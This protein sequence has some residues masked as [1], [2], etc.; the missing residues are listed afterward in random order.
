MSKGNLHPRLAA[1]L[2]VLSLAACGVKNQTGKA[3]VPTRPGNMKLVVAESVL[4]TAGLETVL[5]KVQRV[6]VEGGFWGLA[7]DSGERYNPLNDL[8][9][10]MERDGVRARLAVSLRKDVL[11]TRMWGTPVK[12]YAY[13]LLEEPKR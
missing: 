5:V 7:T 1:S 3:A 13:E 10:E 4:P 2:L 8:P 6:G 12:V 11:T 9:A